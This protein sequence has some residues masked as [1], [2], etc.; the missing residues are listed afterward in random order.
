MSAEED[1]SEGELCS[2]ARP[3]KGNVG[4][5]FNNEL[6]LKHLV[7]IPNMVFGSAQ[8]F[9][10]LIRGYTVRI[11][12]PFKFVKNDKTRVRV[13]CLGEGFEFFVLCSQIRKSRT[14]PLRPWLGTTHVV[15]Q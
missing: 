2:S 3:W 5:E 1:E 12:K 14:C 8:D 15:P 9:K 13:K 11:Q 6:H 4:I 10:K 7:F